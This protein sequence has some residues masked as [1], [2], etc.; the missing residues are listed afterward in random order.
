MKPKNVV[1]DL[2]IYS[3]NYVRSGSAVFFVFIF[4][5]ILM[6]IFGSIFSGTSSSQVPLYVQ[7]QGTN[8]QNTS[9]FMYLLN[10][11]QVVSVHIVPSDV[12]IHTYISQN[13]IS[14]ALV[15][16][17]GFSQNL[18]TNKASLILYDN[19]AVS[20]SGA[21]QQAVSIAIQLMNNRIANK[22]DAITLMTNTSLTSRSAS[23]VDFLMPGLIGFVVLISPMFSMTYVV[24]SY[25]RDKIFRQLS[26]TPLT[27]SEWFLSKFAWY[28]VVSALSA[29]E[30]VAIGTF[31]FNAS[32]AI[33]LFVAAFII[34]GVFMF[35]CLGILAGSVAKTEEGASVV[36][37]IITFP[38]MFLAGTFFP[39]SIM[40]SWL[41]T[42][43]HVLPLYY[44]IDGLNS[45]TTYTNYASA[46]LDL[47]VSVAVALVIFA[48][49][50]WKF[51]W[52]E[53]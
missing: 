11:T 43:A 26:L 17:A 9:E 45:V 36:G 51:D 52:K 39:I 12:N 7:N 23:Y 1:A 22:T 14:A 29:A 20:T 3:K 16:P 42:V 50:I 31:V 2:K 28:L 24:S 13:S 40:P 5:I 37:N 19:P 21:V 47:A 34:I 44:I 25:K 30:I 6:L 46:W 8:N 35:T 33:N 27:K 10:Q 4:P 32:M 48:L 15:I 41:Q 18:S 49:S 53:E 38:M